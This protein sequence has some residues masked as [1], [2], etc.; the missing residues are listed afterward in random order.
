[1]ST[2]KLPEL[3]EILGAMIF[4]ANRPLKVSE[5]KKCLKGVADEQGGE[6]AP[7]GELGKRD[8]DKAVVE[9]TEDIR[10]A[11]LGFILVEVA[12]GFRLQ[13]DA[14]CGPWLKK[15]LDTG[16]PNRLSPPSLE[17]LAIIAYR[18]PISRAEIEGIRGVAVDHVVRA[19]M[20]LQMIRIVGRS[21]LPGRPFLYGTTQLFLEH[22][23]LKSLDEL[24]TMDP[25]LAVKPKALPKPVR[26]VS[27]A[28][29]ELPAQPERV[30]GAEEG[31]E[32]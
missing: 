28:Q 6:L 30:S 31:T 21:E 5:M 11:K 19:L 3:K 14:P 29:P 1:M 23:G 9:L 20:E 25:T 17:T 13:S 2:T 10:Q 24:S 4:G 12:N 7:F 8:I 22:F 26:A 18:Q 15:L 32:T 27:L 16:R